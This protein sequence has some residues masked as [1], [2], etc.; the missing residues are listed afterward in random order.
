MVTDIL[1]SMTVGRHGVNRS[2]IW[3]TTDSAPAPTLPP[4]FLEVLKNEAVAHSIDQVEA[5]VATVKAL[6]YK[7]S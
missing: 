5:E 3:S 2:E 1:A 7:G 4:W 6:H